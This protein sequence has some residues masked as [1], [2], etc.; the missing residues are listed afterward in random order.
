MRNIERELSSWLMTKTKKENIQH[1]SM[2]NTEKGLPTEI[3]KNSKRPTL[4]VL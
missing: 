4:S 3:K 2:R 1:F